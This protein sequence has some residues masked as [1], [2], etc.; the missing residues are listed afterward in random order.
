MACDLVQ[1]VQ[2]NIGGKIAYIECEDKPKLVEFYKRNGFIEF[3]KRPAQ[4]FSM[5]QYSIGMKEGIESNEK[6]KL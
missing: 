4:V 3:N 5:L 2:L 1:E 6:N